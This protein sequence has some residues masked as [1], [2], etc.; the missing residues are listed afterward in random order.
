M[1]YLFD[2]IVLKSHLKVSNYTLPGLA[3]LKGHYHTL[4][5]RVSFPQLL[6]SLY[7]E[8]KNPLRGILFLH[9]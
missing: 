6:L 7:K 8:N 3:K 4:T 1:D 5:V 2:S 9:G